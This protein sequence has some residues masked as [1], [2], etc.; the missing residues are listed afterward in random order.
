MKTNGLHLLS[1]LAACLPLARSAHAQTASVMPTVE[2]DPV[3]SSGD[4]ADD[5]VVWV[6]P[7][8]PS[9]STV[10]GT[11][12]Q[13]GLAVYDLAGNE[14]QFLTDGELNNVDIRYGF[15]LG[16]QRVALVT[17]GERG[18]NAL[19]IYA[20]D[21][22]TRQLRDV[23]ARTIVFGADIYGSC[24]YHSPVTGQYYFFGNSKSGDV[25]QWRLFDNGQ[26]KVDAVRVRTFGV[27]GQ[28]EGCVAD[29]ETGYFFIGEETEGIW[30]YGAE[31]GAG[32]GRI[33]V[34]TT[35]GH[36][37]ADVEG[38]T[39][40]Y[41]SGGKG[42][43]LASSQG[44]SSFVVYDRVAPH[45]YKFTFRVVANSSLGI[46]AVSD[47]D[48]IE[49]MNLGL[50]SAFPDGVFVVQDGANSGGN[51]NFKLVPWSSI[52]NATSPPLLMAPSYD[53]YGARCSSAAWNYRNGSGTNPTILSNLQMPRVGTLWEG[54][55]NCAG[56]APSRGF[57][58]GLSDPAN[59][60][61]ISMGELL[62]DTSSIHLF[63][64]SA[65][66]AGNTIRFRSQIPN[67]ISLCGFE[68]TLQGLCLGAPGA[69]LSNAIDMRLGL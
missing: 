5:S 44:D 54:D 53:V 21:P 35:S 43:L 30:R 15:L 47:T 3:P 16:T 51:Q 62:V 28:T 48:G 60:P 24:M 9:R 49:V 12:K 20:V 25:E 39:I 66:H 58:F 46:D 1:V 8:D 14:L 56:H 36:L 57:V 41:A 23:A 4:A 50:G 34:D 6:H 7:T 17:A 38:L 65:P 67:R 37:T 68:L 11:D 2:T 45:G 19:A 13:S 59:G 61:L 31:P 18:S 64:L 63:T 10:I 22:A 29:D 32:S 33:Q 52:A 27:G 55:L 42:Y 40:F 26:G 69:K